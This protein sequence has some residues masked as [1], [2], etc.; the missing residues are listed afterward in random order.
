[1]TEFVLLFTVFWVAAFNTAIGPSGGVTFAVM[2]STLPPGAAIPLHG[3]LEGVLAAVRAGSLRGHIDWTLTVPFSLGAVCG[4]VLGGFL[5]TDLPERALLLILGVFLLVLTWL[6]YFPARIAA[7][8]IPIPMP[9]LGA[10]SSFATM[11]L[12]AT[13]ILVMAGLSPRLNDRHRLIATHAAAMSVQ[14]GLKIIVF[15]LLGFEFGPY[16]DLF[17]GMLL[18]GVAGNWVGRRLLDRIPETLFRHALRVLVTALALRLIWQA[19]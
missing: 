1:M 18:A 17:A 8:R 2:V 19:I 14:H 16:L 10:V 11:F 5:V 13:G 6:A 3:M 9:L 7:P 12:G 4:A 15:G